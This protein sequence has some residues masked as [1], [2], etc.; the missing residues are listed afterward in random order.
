M[1]TA[2]IRL[3]DDVSCHRLQIEAPISRTAAMEEILTGLRATVTI[4][5]NSAALGDDTW[6]KSRELQWAGYDFHRAAAPLGKQHL[7]RIQLRPAIGSHRY[8]YVFPGGLSTVECDDLCCYLIG[9][10]NGDNVQNREW[11]VTSTLAGLLHGDGVSLADHV[12][13]FAR[14][15]TIPVGRLTIV[16]ASPPTTLH[17]T[18]RDRGWF[19]TVEWL[20]DTHTT[21]EQALDT[22]RKD[23]AVWVPASAPKLPWEPLILQ[24]RDDQGCLRLALGAEAAAY[25]GR[26]VELAVSDAER[27]DWLSDQDA[28]RIADKSQ[29]QWRRWI[30]THHQVRIGRRIGSDGHP[31]KNRRLIHRND[32]RRAIRL[33]QTPGK[34]GEHIC[35]AHDCWMSCVNAGECPRRKR[36]P[37]P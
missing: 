12:I 3:Y 33:A 14:G 18:V 2:M 37:R 21:L 13:A 32:L 16:P 20:R 7:T 6:L 9:G 4:S 10:D 17:A 22:I 29:G 8:E 1:Q 19:A 23:R 34:Q 24:Y 15:R 27:A 30:E 5:V 35:N 25:A 28:A 36:P 11:L 26:R 31:A